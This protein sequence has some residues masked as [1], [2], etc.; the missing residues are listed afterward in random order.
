M[1]GWPDQPAFLLGRTFDVLVRNRLGAAL[2]EP[3]TYSDNLLLNIFLDDAAPTFFKH[4]H[5][6]AVNTVAAFRAAAGTAPDDR[7]V[8]PLLRELR[9]ASAA[10]VDIWA[11]NDARGK[12]RRS[13]DVRPPRGR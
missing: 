3:F 9:R 12:E 5:V 4:W 8:I 6:A 10:F 1:D 7:P 11:R 2:W 13:Q